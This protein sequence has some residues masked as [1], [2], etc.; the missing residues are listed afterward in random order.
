MAGGP[1]FDHGPPTIDRRL[2]FLLIKKMKHKTMV[3]RPS[4][5][6]N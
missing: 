3:Y 6:V 5:M 1:G 2:L 4:S